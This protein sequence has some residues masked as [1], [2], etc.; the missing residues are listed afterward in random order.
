MSTTRTRPRSSSSQAVVPAEFTL[1]DFAN[2]CSELTLEDKS[3]F[4]LYPEQETILADY[5]AG[6]TTNAIEAGPGYLA[7]RIACR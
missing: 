7:W 2:F 6:V 4:L 1:G 3:P 5:F